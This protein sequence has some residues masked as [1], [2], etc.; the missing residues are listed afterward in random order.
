VVKG[1]HFLELAESVD[2]LYDGR[3]FMEF[4]A[5]RIESKNTHGTGCTFSSAIAAN[6][7]LG[8]PL[9]EAVR[10]AKAY[11]SRIIAASVELG[12][13]RGFGPMNHMAK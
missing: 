11:V 3:D 9:Y 4:S 6:F 1:G 10:S 7:A 5:P 2:V 8:L 13:G 12:I